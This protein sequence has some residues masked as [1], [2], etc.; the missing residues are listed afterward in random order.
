MSAQ[1]EYYQRVL[2]NNSGVLRGDKSQDWQKLQSLCVLLRQCCNHPYMLA[3]VE[4]TNDDGSISETTEET[5]RPQP[6]N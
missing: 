4:V 1:T 5:V 3:G 2:R 6:D